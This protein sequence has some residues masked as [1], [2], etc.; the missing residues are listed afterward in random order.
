MVTLL[1]INLMRVMD[2]GKPQELADLL[3]EAPQNVQ[4]TY[5]SVG[6]LSVVVKK[7]VNFA[8][9]YI[10]NINEY[11]NESICISRTGSTIRWN[12]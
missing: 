8:Y 2:N 12:G 6:L 7:I 5:K 1:V 10:Y 11:N 4:K 3:T 9:L